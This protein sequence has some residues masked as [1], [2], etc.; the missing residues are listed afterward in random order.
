MKSKGTVAEQA[1]AHRRVVD[2]LG[3]RRQDRKRGVRFSIVNSG[4]NP[5]SATK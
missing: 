2:K 1:D 4:S 5:D 3:R